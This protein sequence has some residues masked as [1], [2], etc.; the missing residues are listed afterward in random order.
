MN[1]LGWSA[2]RWTSRLGTAW[3]LDIVLVLS[4]FCQI[5]GF[6][7]KREAVNK[8]PAIPVVINN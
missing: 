5:C 4:H 3:F 8:G 2:G 1:G 6:S 7:F